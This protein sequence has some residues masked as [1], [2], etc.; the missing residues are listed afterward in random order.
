MKDFNAFDSVPLC[1]L[2]EC[3]LYDICK[4]VQSIADKLEGEYNE[5][6]KCGWQV[7][8][9][10]TFIATT[11]GIKLSK[12]D[13]IDFSTQAIPIYH[14]V[15]KMQMTETMLQNNILVKKQHGES[16]IH[17][18]LR[19]KRDAISK[20]NA[21]PIMKLIRSLNIEKKDKLKKKKEAKIKAK[22]EPVV[23]E[24]KKV[25]PFGDKDYQDALDG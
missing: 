23:E 20:L 7:E 3:N 1:N 2:R 9:L 12:F 14:D 13:M 25:E 19:E 10:T 22:V 11:K 18:V 24:E 17:A 5:E 21:L 8:Y 4:H 15:I 16:A 6:H